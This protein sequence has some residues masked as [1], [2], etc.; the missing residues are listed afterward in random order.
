[1]N[2][3]KID[4][5]MISIIMP[6]YNQAEFIGQAIESVLKQT[7]C[8]FELII[9]SKGGEVED[10]CLVYVGEVYIIYSQQVIDTGRH[11]EG[12]FTPTVAEA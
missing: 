1:M 2:D 7:Y 10:F 9:I 4:Q 6:T 11:I 12:T 8:N 3:G 5:A